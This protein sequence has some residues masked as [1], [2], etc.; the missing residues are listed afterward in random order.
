MYANTA[1]GAVGAMWDAHYG[2][3]N[4][5][6]DDDYTT[7]EEANEPND[8]PYCGTEE[9]EYFYHDKHGLILGCVNCVKTAVT[10]VGLHE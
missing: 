1:S 8:C 2:G 10:R 6:Y 7:D 3:E 5:Y 4:D 9:P